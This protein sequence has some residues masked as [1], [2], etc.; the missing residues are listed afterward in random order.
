MQDLGE[1]VL[2]PGLINAHCHLDYSGMRGAILPPE[3]FTAWIGRINALKRELTDEDYLAAIQSG[4]EQCLRTGTTSLVNI[5]AFPELMQRLPTPPIRTWWCYELIDIR[6]RIATDEVISGALTFFGQRTGWL[7]GFGLSPHA[8][9]TASA[10]LY[11]LAMAAAKAHGMPVTTHLAESM[12]EQQMF[13]T[14]TGPLY[15]FLR[16]IGRPMDDCGRGESALTVLQSVGALEASCLVAHLNLLTARDEEL[17]APG[18]PLHGLSVVHCPTSHSYFRHAEFRFDRLREL[19]ANICLGTDS[20][21]SSASLDLF[22]E[23][24]TF[25]KLHSN[26]SPAELL[27]LVTQNPARA[28]GAS[29]R[30]GVLAPEAE[31]DLIALPL[32]PAGDVLEA[33][34]QRPATPTAV[35]VAGRQMLGS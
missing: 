6:H 1:Q 24:H 33:V 9:Y 34:V 30:L 20:L 3:S 21:A 2:M 27:A 11:R 31:A 26:I 23:L 8:P 28:L 18:G 5:E 25:A 22:D 15:D 14:A 17:L 10:E 29:G 13:L 16:G 12:D 32:A 35:W 19:G 7:G 4:F